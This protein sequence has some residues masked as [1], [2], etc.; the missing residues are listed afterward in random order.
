M[1]DQILGHWPGRASNQGVPIVSTK[2][3]GL[4]RIDC[5]K[6]T[7]IHISIDEQRLQ[8]I[9]AIPDAISTTKDRPG[10]ILNEETLREL[11]R[12]VREMGIVS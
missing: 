5:C 10:L 6:D 1:T 9:S 12:V 11:V 4:L 7:L 2:Y 8:E 3:A